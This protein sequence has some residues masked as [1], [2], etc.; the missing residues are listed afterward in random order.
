MTAALTSGIDC[1]DDDAPRLV[2]AARP[3]GVSFPQSSW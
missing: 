3:G 2:D 1:P